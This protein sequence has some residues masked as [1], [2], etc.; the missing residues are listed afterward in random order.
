MVKSRKRL[1]PTTT[2]VTTTRIAAVENDSFMHGISST[3]I[4]RLLHAA[5]DHRYKYG[6]ALPDEAALLRESKARGLRQ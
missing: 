6:R 2:H 3:E 5:E 1:P 4:L